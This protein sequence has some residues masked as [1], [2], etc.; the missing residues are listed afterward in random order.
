MN[1]ELNLIEQDIGIQSNKEKNVE[2]NY[3][4]EEEDLE[5]F[6]LD[7]FGFSKT[8]IKKE[9]KKE[10]KKEEKLDLKNKEEVM[11]IIIKTKR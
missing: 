2:N 9:V 10:E 11:K 8:E 6:L 5:Q 1:E 7:D 3:K 4:K